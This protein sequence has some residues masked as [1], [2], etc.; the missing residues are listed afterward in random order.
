MNENNFKK[1]KNDIIE[2]LKSN[3]VFYDRLKRVLCCKNL[4]EL[5]DIIIYD[6]VF[7]NKNN[8]K[9]PNGYYKNTYREFTISNGKINGEYIIYHNDG[10]ILMKCNYVNG[11]LNGEQINFYEKDKL[12]SKSNFIEDD[13][14]GEYIYYHL[15]GEISLKCYYVKNQKHGKYIEYDDKGNIKKIFMY[16]NGVIV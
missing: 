7:F 2:Q 16:N 9:L 15:N 3:R 1:A 14:D 13:L 5:E 8:I 12:F 11:K 4:S 10:Q 6:I